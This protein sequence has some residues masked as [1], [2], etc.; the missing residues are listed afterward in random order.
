[1]TTKHQ[2]L[3]ALLPVGII[4]LLQVSCTN[5]RTTE[6]EKSDIPAKEIPKVETE[7]A[8]LGHL[9]ASSD[10]RTTEIPDEGSRNKDKATTTQSAEDE[11]STQEEDMLKKVVPGSSPEFTGFLKQSFNRV[12]LDT[13]YPFTLMDAVALT[14]QYNRDIKASYTQ[15]Q[16]SLGNLEIAK[17]TFDLTTQ[18]QWNTAPSYVYLGQNVAQKTVSS[19]YS[20]GFSKLSRFGLQT[21]AT[22]SFTGQDVSPNTDY[23]QVGEGNMALTFTM[24]LFRSESTDAQERSRRLGLEA[25]LAAVIHQINASLNTT[26][27]NYWSYAAAVQN[28]IIGIEALERSRETLKNTTTLVENILQEPSSLNALSADYSSKE[29][30][31]QNYEQQLVAARNKLAISL[32]FPVTKAQLL[33]MPTSSFPEFEADKACQIKRNM[34]SL[35]KLALTNR[36]DYKKAELQMKSA[37]ILEDKY[38]REFLPN[39][40]L[41]AGIS[42]TGF[43]ES[44]TLSKE[45]ETASNGDNAIT[46]GI[47]MALPWNNDNA[48]GQL[49]NQMGQTEGLRLAYMSAKE[50][51]ASDINDNANA[52][53]YAVGILNAQK[54]AEQQYRKATEDEVKKF[55]L[56]LSSIL[57]VLSVADRLNTARSSTIIAQANLATAITHLRYSTGTLLNDKEHGNKLL[58]EDFTTPLPSVLLEGFEETGSCN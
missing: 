37:R 26:I 47:Q 2:F 43:T 48:R 32:G 52:L 51:I 12:S 1:M 21:N 16:Q 28:L 29:S 40:N 22:F 14:V 56:G 4:L 45:L 19:L 15:Y 55:H 42:H 24:P 36:Q 58:L 46:L 17:G 5:Y 3:R 34:P 11:V 18:L 7:T 49:R 27:E 41:M 10:E 8:T 57:D 9:I 50:T 38:R 20:L 6:L 30:S 54:L 25:S 35:L 33:P 23:G 53:F 13:K 31:R 39:V 44:S